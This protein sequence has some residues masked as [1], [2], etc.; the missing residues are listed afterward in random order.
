MDI[1]VM[2]RSEAKN[3]RPEVDTWCISITDPFARTANLRRYKRGLRL[4]FYDATDGE[5]LMT[6]TD[7]HL[8]WRFVYNALEAN[9]PHM[10]I[11]CEA[12]IS[13]SAAVATAIVDHYGERVTWVNRDAKLYV[14]G[15]GM[16]PR[17]KP[18]PFVFT[19]LTGKVLQP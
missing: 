4:N 19:M 6:E 3:H 7:V 13:R 17:F 10:V 15:E 18:N 14:V 11:H 9:I 8:V 16:V 2:S 12:G 5:L 1:T